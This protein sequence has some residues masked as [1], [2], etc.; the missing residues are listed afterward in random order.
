MNAT[1][2]LSRTIEYINTIFLSYGQKAV[3]YATGIIIDLAPSEEIRLFVETNTGTG[4]ETVG[5]VAQIVFIVGLNPIVAVRKELDLRNQAQA[6]VEEFE[7]L[8]ASSSVITV[9]IIIDDDLVSQ[10]HGTGRDGVKIA[11]PKQGFSE[12]PFQRE[13]AESIQENRKVSTKN[14]Y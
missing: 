10:C 9:K 14:H 13:K 8:L 7:F 1:V 11:T 12:D 6:F 2:L 5:Q 4:R 3:R